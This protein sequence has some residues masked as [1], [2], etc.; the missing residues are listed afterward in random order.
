MLLDMTKVRFA[1]DNTDPWTTLSTAT[2][3][4]LAKLHRDPGKDKRQDEHETENETEHAESDAP[5][6]GGVRLAVG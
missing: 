1:N 3:R 6:T 2:E 5:T 4:A